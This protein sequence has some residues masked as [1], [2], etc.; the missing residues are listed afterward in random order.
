[1]PSLGS[2]IKFDRAKDHLRTLDDRLKTFVRDHP[3]TFT[4]EPIPRP[5]DYVVLAHGYVAP[6]PAFGAIIGDFAH[7]ARSAL[8]LVIS[9]ISKLPADDKRR[10]RL[11]FPIFDTEVGGNSYR[12]REKSYLDGVGSHERAIVEDFQPYKR[13][14]D[15]A[16]EPLGIL[17]SV[18][19]ADKHRLIHTISAVSTVLIKLNGPF[20]LSDGEGRGTINVGA[21]G[22]MTFSAGMRMGGLEIRI[23]EDA[24]I[25]Q[26]HAPVAL[27][28]DV[29]GKLGDVNMEPKV[30]TQMNFGEGSSRAEGRAVMDTLTEIL[31][32]VEEVL[33]KF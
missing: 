28:R 11:Q 6:D 31:N 10:F 23:M 27:V 3:Y 2:Q 26:E 5:P 13:G 24:G 16:N 25:T 12:S 21:G 22:S 32:R 30:T 18:N 8:D 33:G 7:N 19:D 14:T 29:S 20:T 17:A 1:M 15:F 4:V 9:D